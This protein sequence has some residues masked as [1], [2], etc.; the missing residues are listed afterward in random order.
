MKEL[1]ALIKQKKELS[2]LDDSFIKTELQRYLKSHQISTI[3]TKPKQ[4]KIIVKDLRAKLR[5]FS[6]LF[7]AQHKKFQK[8]LPQLLIDP[9]NTQLITQLLQTHAS[10]KE[11][12]QIYQKLYT[13]IIPKNTKTILDLG[14]GIN[15]LAYTYLDCKPTYN[16]FD[17]NTTQI[18]AINQYFNAAKIQGQA[19]ILNLTQTT[20]ISS[21]PKADLALCFKVTDLLDRN[22]GHKPT[23]IFLQAIP[24]KTIILS[25]STKTMSGKSMTSPKRP[26]LT[27]LCDRLHYKYQILE[28][29]TE[30]FYIIVK[31]KIPKPF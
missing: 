20:K 15:P 22:K 6:T 10:T 31:P 18:H 28:Y 13:Q 14:C 21:L 25:F 19:Q 4:Q 17:I 16:A 5:R 12:L 23:E 7:P 26:W 9:Q 1:I 3:P 27:W 30:I 8:I 11:R 2:H 24:A 29:P